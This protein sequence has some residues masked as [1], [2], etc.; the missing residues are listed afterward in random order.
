MKKILCIIASLLFSGLF[1][2]PVQAITKVPYLGVEYMPE[3][4]TMYMK[5][6]GLKLEKGD[7]ILITDKRGSDTTKIGKIIKSTSKNR[8]LVEIQGNDGK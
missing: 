4:K 8:Y 2:Y 3:G 6:K 7:L 5:I 1:I